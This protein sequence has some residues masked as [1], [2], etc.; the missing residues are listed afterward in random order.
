[1]G[2]S[3]K[4]LR[5]ILRKEYLKVGKGRRWEIPMTMARKVERDFKVRVKA[6]EQKP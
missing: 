3:P 5:A 1:M 4:R 6:K 2:I